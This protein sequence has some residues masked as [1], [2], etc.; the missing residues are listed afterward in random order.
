MIRDG[1][2]GAGEPAPSPLDR[3]LA[4]PL[5]PWL[6]S[7]GA[8][9]MAVAIL[10]GFAR[11]GGWAEVTALW[12]S[13]WFRVSIVDVYAGLLVIGAW[14]ASRERPAAAACWAL[15]LV[16]TGNFATFVYLLRASRRSRARIRCGHVGTETAPCRW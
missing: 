3:L 1:T 13:P 11:G 2:R 10:W 4:R 7:A 5:V 9:L 15:A 12:S 14:I 16:L 8:A 6:A